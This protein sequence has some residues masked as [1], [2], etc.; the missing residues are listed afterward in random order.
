MRWVAFLPHILHHDVLSH[1]KPQ[2][3]GAGLKPLKPWVSINHSSFCLCHT[4]CHSDEKTNTH[5]NTLN[6]GHITTL[7]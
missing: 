5:K 3:S 4:F 6:S 1:F 2:H 7:L